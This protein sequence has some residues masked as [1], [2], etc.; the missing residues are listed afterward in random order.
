MDGIEAI[1]YVNTRFGH[2]D[3]SI[4]SI[5]PGV[6]GLS[7]VT[8][9]VLVLLVPQPFDAFTEIVPATKL[10]GK[11]SEMLLV[12]CPLKLMPPVTFHV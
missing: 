11:V 12:P 8:A 9:R 4:T 7:L 2:G 3:V 1:V 6:A 10:D 5:T